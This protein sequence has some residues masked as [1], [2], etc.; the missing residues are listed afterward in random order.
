MGCWVCECEMTRFENQ[1]VM[2]DDIAI[3]CSGHVCKHCGEIT[4]D[5]AETER[6][7]KELEEGKKRYEYD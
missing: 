6:I 3:I 4:F 7:L 2:F 5:G 1:V